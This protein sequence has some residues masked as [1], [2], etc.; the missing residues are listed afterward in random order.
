M[1]WVQPHLH[2]LYDVH[3]GMRVHSA[4][5]TQLKGY[6]CQLVL[7]SPAYQQGTALIPWALKL[8]ASRASEQT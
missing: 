3:A 1:T 8:H 7:S 2:W 4:C 6:G 5:A